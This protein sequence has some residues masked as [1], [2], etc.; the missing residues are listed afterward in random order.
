MDDIE[1]GIMTANQAA[2]YFGIGGG[3]TVYNWLAT[4]GMNAAKG[5]KVIIMSPKED[6]ELMTLRKEM[7]L[8]KK[9]LE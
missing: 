8:L 7:A 6:T 2:K 9:Q 1:S 5:R 4:Y 3:A